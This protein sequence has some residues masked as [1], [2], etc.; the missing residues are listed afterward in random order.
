LPQVG[1]GSSVLLT[2]THLGSCFTKY[3]I[4]FYFV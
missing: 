3:N 1:A 2:P 4:I